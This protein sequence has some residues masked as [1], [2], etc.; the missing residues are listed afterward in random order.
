MAVTEETARDVAAG[1]EKG[2]VALDDLTPNKFRLGA[3]TPIVRGSALT[4]QLTTIT[5]N[6]PTPDFAIQGITSSSPFGFVSADEGDTVM[7]VI[8]N[9]QVRLAEVEARI[10]ALGLIA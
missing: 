10:V 9:L 4:A 5:F 2:R 1:V 6:A 8:A 7:S 3:G